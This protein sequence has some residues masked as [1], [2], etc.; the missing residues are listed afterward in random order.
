M[1][2][3]ELADYF[4]NLMTMYDDSDDGDSLIYVVQDEW[5]IFSDKLH[6]SDRSAELMEDI[7]NSDW[8]D[9]SGEGPVS[10]LDPVRRRDV[11]PDLE[12]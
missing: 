3:G 6:E 9:D 8:D 7:L 4:H 1:P 10:A 12:S 11:L 5:Y 2:I